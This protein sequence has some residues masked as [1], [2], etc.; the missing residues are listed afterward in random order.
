[1]FEAVVA[2]RNCIYFATK[3]GGETSAAEK[4]RLLKLYSQTG[5]FSDVQRL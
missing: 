2:L 4:S 1:L 5:C 3:D